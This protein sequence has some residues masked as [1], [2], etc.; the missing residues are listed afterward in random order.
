MIMLMATLQLKNVPQTVHDEVGRRARDRGWTVRDYLLD[1]IERDQQFPT[2][3][4]WLLRI[5]RLRPIKTGPSAAEL[6]QESRDER[7]QQLSGRE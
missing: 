6:I 3:E 4:E 2:R 7:E 5:R 1:L